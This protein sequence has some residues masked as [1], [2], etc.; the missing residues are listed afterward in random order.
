MK[1]EYLSYTNGGSTTPP[2]LSTLQPCCVFLPL[3]QSEAIVRH[4]LANGL[5]S[6][7]EMIASTDRNYSPHEA[8]MRTL[9]CSDVE[10]IPKAQP[11][12]TF[13]KEVHHIP[14]SM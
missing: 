2:V 6:F 10:Q 1:A 11:L 14:V 12:R 3:S 4:V 13:D 7:C 9:F 5:E 8:T